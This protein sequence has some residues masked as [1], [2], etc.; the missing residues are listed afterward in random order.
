M[1]VLHVLR[2]DPS[3]RHLENRRASGHRWTCRAS[4]TSDSP[5]CLKLV[6]ARWVATKVFLRLTYETG[7]LTDP[8]NWFFR[9][10]KGCDLHYRQLQHKLVVG[11]YVEAAS[12]Y[13]SLASLQLV[14]GFC[15]FTGGCLALCSGGH[16]QETAM[17]SYHQVSPTFCRCCIRSPC[18]SH[19]NHCQNYA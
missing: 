19:T 9:V 18:C 6:F 11:I 7:M 17:L 4:Q 12:I 8:A 2:H 15:C 5:A 14:L 1:T 3:R 13:L 16:D 10:R